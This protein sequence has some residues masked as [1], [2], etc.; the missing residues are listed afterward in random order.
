M[1]KPPRPIRWFDDPKGADYPAAASYLS[2]LHSPKKAKKLVSNL[3]KAPVTEYKSK[4]IFR[5]SGLPLLPPAN[6]HV[7]RDRQK[8]RRG[9]RLSPILLVR[10][11]KHG[12]V[13][14]ADGYHR[15]CAVYSFHEDAVVRCKISDP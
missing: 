15:L 4:D 2:L 9:E 3:K 6:F 1:S 5:A 8:I 13:V 10:D 11:P 14:I 7:A 12:K